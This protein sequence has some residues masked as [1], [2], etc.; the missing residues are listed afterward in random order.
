M[1]PPA[2]ARLSTTNCWPKRCM[3]FSATARDMRSVGPEGAKGTIQR[4]GRFGYVSPALWAA[5]AEQISAAESAARQR[6]RQLNTSSFWRTPESILTF[7][8][9]RKLHATHL[10]SS[11]TAPDHGDITSLAP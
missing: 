7:G 11:A 3:S 9:S 10:T 6:A 8:L 5:A 2:P 1:F 4:T